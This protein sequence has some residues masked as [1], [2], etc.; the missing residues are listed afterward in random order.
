[1]NFDN[2]KLQTR[3]SRA[4]IYRIR[5]KA[6]SRGWMPG[7]T[8][9]TWMVDDSPRSGRPPINNEVRE[10]ILSILTRNSSTRGW[11]C[12]R[13]ASEVTSITSG[14]KSVSASTVYRVLT[15]EGYG[16]FK[17]TVKPGLTQEQK[18]ARLKFCL[19]H[20]WMTLED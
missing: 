3:I 19:D 15:S 20:E 17:R 9:E 8:I 4:S 7:T 5:T 18:E 6:I 14:V 10:L 13:I 1:M 16:V 12:A 2:I 11:S